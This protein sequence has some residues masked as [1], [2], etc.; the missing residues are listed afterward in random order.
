MRFRNCLDLYSILHASNKISL[1]TDLIK[2]RY[3]KTEKIGKQAFFMIFL[4]VL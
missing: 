3:K 4:A 2:S 1:D